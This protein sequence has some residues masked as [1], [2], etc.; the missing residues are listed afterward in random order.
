MCID[1][2]HKFQQ[3]QTVINSTMIDV[4]NESEFGEL[5]LRKWVENE[6]L[7]KLSQTF[8]QSTCLNIKELL[9]CETIFF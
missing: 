5:W 8:I 1:T 3:R 2:D 4:A 7:I 6:E 9:K